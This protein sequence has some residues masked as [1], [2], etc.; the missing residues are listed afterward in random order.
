MFPYLCVN[1]QLGVL[2]A[3]GTALIW[4]TTTIMARIFLRGSGSLS[5]NFLRLLISA[6]FYAVLFLYTGFPDVGYNIL[7][8]IILSS[9]A[10]FV[11]GDFFFFSA[12]KLMG[13]SR[14]VLIVTMYPLWTIVFAHFLIGREISM[15][16][17]LGAL[18]IIF[19]VSLIIV[20]KEEVKLHPLGVLYAI[21]AQ[22][23]WALA[24]VS[25]DWLLEGLQVYQVTGLRI[26]AAGGI[27]IFLLPFPWIRND[28]RKLNWKGYLNATLIA[29]FGIVIAQYTFTLAISYAG[30][31]IAA[32]VAETSPLLATIFAKLILREV[33]SNRLFISVILMVLGVAIMMSA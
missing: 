27:S 25:I 30:S 15:M 31:E 6:P 32:P 18:L 11:I 8:I 17:V 24:V 29:I 20:K 16:V 28:L 33:I 2:L 7:T 4:A 10:G 12:M 23:L 3:F 19:A 21:I 22:F 5:L 26:M 1:V 9:L 14:S 13:V